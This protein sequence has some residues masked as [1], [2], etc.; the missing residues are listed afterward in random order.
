VLKITENASK[1][2]G[3]L[4]KSNKDGMVPRVE[5]IAGGCN[6]FETKFSMDFFKEDDIKV[7]LSPDIVVLV[8]TMTHDM[9]SNSVIDF[10]NSLNNSRFSVKIPEAVSTCGCGASFGL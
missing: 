3:E 1:R 4:I 10:K 8:D 5:V 7:E 9:L 6:G 2:F